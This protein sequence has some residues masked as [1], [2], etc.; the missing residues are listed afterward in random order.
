MHWMDFLV[1]GLLG[2]ILTNILN[3]FLEYPGD[4]HED[5]ED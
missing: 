2:M 3:I 1:G 5:E 4:M